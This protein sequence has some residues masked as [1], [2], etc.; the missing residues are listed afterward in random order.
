ML[1]PALPLETVME[2]DGEGFHTN[3]FISMGL[4]SSTRTLTEVGSID[5]LSC[6]P[7]GRHLTAGIVGRHVSTVCNAG[8]A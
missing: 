3:R 1:L 4:G 6:S 5:R 2:N 8:T 7:I